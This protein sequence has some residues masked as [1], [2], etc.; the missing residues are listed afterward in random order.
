[1]KH[2][3]TLTLGLA[4]LVCSAVAA[5]ASAGRPNGQLFQFRGEVVSATS[6][7]VQITVEGGNHAA[8]RMMLGL[9]F[10]TMSLLLIV[11]W[12]RFR[13]SPA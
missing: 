11:V 10:C 7:S 1:M 5:T 6:T 2:R 12:R 3:L 9:L 4:A 8:L 13:L